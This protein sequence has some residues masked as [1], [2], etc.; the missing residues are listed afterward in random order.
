MSSNHIDMYSSYDGTLNNMEL[1]NSS[2]IRE[3]TETG[4][5]NN[6]TDITFSDNQSVDD[7]IKTAVLKNEPIEDKLNVIIVISNPCGFKRRY[8]LANQF[9]DRIKTHPHVMLYVVELVY[10][11]KV[12]Q[13]TDSLNPTHLQLRGTTPLWHKENMINIGVKRLLPPN[14]KAFAWVD[15]DIEFDNIHWAQDTLRILNGSRDIV[16]LFTHAVDMDMRTDPLQIFQGFG[17][18]YDLKKPHGR[19]GL[20]FWHPGYAWACTRA[21]YEQMGGIYQNSILGAGDHNMALCFIGKGVGAVV[22]QGVTESYKQNLFEFEIRVKS[23]KLGYVPGVIRHYFHGSKKNRK[24]TERWKIL[25]G[26]QYDPLV[27][28][29]T[30]TD[31]LIVPTESC[32]PQL[33]V[34]IMNYFRERNEDEGMLE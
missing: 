25:V 31:G 15:A 3:P 20:N 12:H 34:D 28:I 22:D 29:T 14:W 26:H 11:E 13:L 27:H 18:Q 7:D 24:Y 6:K 17:Y 21:A 19:P 8:E 1:M 9:I 23:L 4:Y 33:L 5:M 16:Q 10:G 32:P 30:N 2:I